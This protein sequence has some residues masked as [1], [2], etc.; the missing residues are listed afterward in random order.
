MR[1]RANIGRWCAA[2]ALAAF[3]L[4]PGSAFAESECSVDSDCGENFVCNLSQ[5]PCASP[6]P[7]DPGSGEEC[8]DMP[9]CEPETS[10]R[11][12]PAPPESCET[13]ADCEGGL[14]CVTYTYETCTGWAEPACDPSGESCPEPG[15]TPDPECTTETEGYCLPPYLAPC[16]SASDCGEGFECNA[17]EICSCSGGGPTD[18]GA[19]AEGGD[20]EGGEQPM[21]PQEDCACEPG[22]VKYCELPE[23]ECQT[24]ADC[25]GELICAELPG[26][27]S[28]APDGTCT[29]T[30]D[31]ETVCEE[32]ESPEPQES[33]SYCLPA[34]F[35]R[36]IGSGIPG[37]AGYGSAEDDAGAPDGE[38]HSNG[39]EGDRDFVAAD[40]DRG[41]APQSGGDAGQDMDDGCGCASTGNSLPGS[42]AALFFALM[43]MAG[44]RRRSSK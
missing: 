5:A 38:G 16:E 26:G 35:E 9:A 43:G 6:P 36:W 39:G 15:P 17:P 44:L 2:A 7:C 8:Q 41:D 40:V 29:S 42:F 21:P 1:M 3:C 4:A 37:H 31:G 28:P 32:F 13:V 22:D 34:D 24:D 30:P 18:P 33:V 25:A 10:G 11:C 27:M 14:V 20:R 19:P 12:E 23:Q